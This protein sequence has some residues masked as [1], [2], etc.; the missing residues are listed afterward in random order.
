MNNGI[1]KDESNAISDFVR[2]MESFTK[3]CEAC[4]GNGILDERSG[5]IYGSVICPICGGDDKS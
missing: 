4:N 2:D 1:T 5:F 3:M